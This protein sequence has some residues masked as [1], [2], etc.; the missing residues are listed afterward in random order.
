MTTPDFETLY[1]PLEATLLTDAYQAIT[2]CGLWDWMRTF[3]PEDGKGFMFSGHPNLDRI[4]AAMKYDGHSGASYGWTMRQMESLA[5][6]GWEEHK[7]TGRRTR[8]ERELTEWAAT[9]HKPKG[10]PCP[11]RAAQGFTDGWCGVAGGGVPG[12]DH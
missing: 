11:C 4:N 1:G 10:N 5:K 9:Q 7:N 12:C 8:A 2:T 6:I 3:S